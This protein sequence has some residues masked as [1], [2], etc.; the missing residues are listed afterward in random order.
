MDSLEVLV[1]HIQGFLSNFN[2]LSHLHSL[3]KQ[4]ED[5]LRYQANRLASV[6]GQLDPS[7]HSLGNLFIL[8]AVIPN[9]S[10]KQKA[11]ELV[12]IVANFIHSCVSDQI[13]LAPE[14]FISVCKRFKDDVILL[15]AP[16][17]GVASMR[18]AVQKLRPSSEH[19]TALHPDFLLLCILAKGYKAGL[20]MLEEDDIFEVDQP[21]N[22][23]LYCYYGGMICIG[24]KRFG[25][26]LE[27]LKN[28]FTAPMNLL[29]AIAV[30]A[31]KKYILISL[32]H[33][34]QF[35]T[36]LPKYTSSIAGR[37]LKN[38]SQILLGNY[39]SMMDLGVVGDVDT[40]GFLIRAYCKDG[41]FEEGSECINYTFT[42]ESSL[43][44][45]RLVVQLADNA[46]SHWMRGLPVIVRNV[47]EKTFGLSWEPMV[48]WRAFRGA[49]GNLEEEIRNVK[50]IDCLD[51]CEVEIDIHQFFSG[52][53]EDPK[54]G[55]L[56]LATKLP[57]N[58]S[59][60][61][62]IPKTYIAYGFSEELGRGDSV[63]KLHCD[64]S[65]AVNGLTYTTEVKIT[66]WQ[67]NI[68]KHTQKENEV[69][70]L[71]EL[72]VEINDAS[73]EATRKSFN[74]P[75]EG[76]KPELAKQ[77]V[78]L[79]NQSSSLKDIVSSNCGENLHYNSLLERSGRV[80]DVTCSHGVENTLLSE[81]QI[82]GQNV[83]EEAVGVKMTKLDKYHT[84]RQGHHKCQDVSH[85][86]SI[87]P[88]STDLE[89]IKRE[90][91][92]ERSTSEQDDFYNSVSVNK[93][94]TVPEPQKKDQ[95]T[96]GDSIHKN[97]TSK[98]V[99]R[100]AVWDIFRRE[101]VPKLMEYLDKHQNEFRDRNNLPVNAFLE[102]LHIYLNLTGRYS[103]IIWRFDSCV[104]DNI[105]SERS[106]CRTL[107][108]VQYLGDAVFIP[109]GCPHQV[110]NKQSCI[111]V[112]LDIVS[113]EN[114]QECVRL[115]E[116]FRL[117]PKNHRAKEDKLEVKK[118]TLHAV[119]STVLEARSLIS[120]LSSKNG[121]KQG[122]GLR[123]FLA[124][125][126]KCRGEHL[127]LRHFLAQVPRS[128]V[129]VEVEVEDLFIS[130]NLVMFLRRITGT[131]RPF[132]ARFFTTG[133]NHPDL[134][135]AI[136]ELN[137]H[138]QKPKVYTIGPL[139]A[140]LS[141]KI[142]S[143]S[144]TSLRAVDRS[145]LTWLDLQQLKS[146]L[147]VSFGSIAVVTAKQLLEFWYGI[148]NSDKPF[149]WVMRPDSII[150]EHQ[151]LEELMLATK[152]RGCMVDWSPQEEVLAHSSIGGFLTHSGWN[153]TLEAITAGVPMLCAGHILRTNKLIAG[154]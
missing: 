118:M 150:G 146:V 52:Y 105:Q 46:Q 110:R 19:L 93:D 11:G 5:Y 53:L 16:I 29:N 103:F 60:P 66:S 115:T 98:V 76:E 32:I 132:V 111:K 59:K 91:Q 38:Y 88:E 25:K 107:D 75:C 54:S 120:K 126:R 94:A 70:D 12:P 131:S 55:L 48:M 128:D 95:S 51:W 147:Y 13:R 4:S 64:M 90:K 101:D 122:L 72:N 84:V 145:C 30:E 44:V 40:V 69:D 96:K 26:A 57:D 47:L 113:P 23:F 6:L 31:Y 92:N 153:S 27:L 148:V 119:N 99:N 43:P 89:L 28:V 37:H 129:E 134:P 86:I 80:D 141:F 151:I 87:V 100:G 124:Q 62:L 1:A 9:S 15:G 127:M 41:N 34:G 123:H 108:I 7:K 74:Q 36:T 35:S 50:V 68:I 58:C 81:G 135:N 112:A 8:E 82:F 65:D 137:K 18:I 56:N 14:K 17:R 121:G 106:L 39:M 104:Y 24:Q 109:A 83:I 45:G 130:G 140:L 49:K 117:L 77:V 2:D 85:S 63:T 143:S 20:G 138:A 10:S 33:N 78:I 133:N 73:D 139:S 42:Y 142:N 152:E 22:L 154:T 125:A 79:D 67:Q 102:S 144:S 114:V 116:E 3:L 136:A 97:D 61:D 21:R 71:M 149:L